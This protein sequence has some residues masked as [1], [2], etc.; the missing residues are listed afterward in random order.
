MRLVE[1]CHVTKYYPAK[2]GEYPSDISKFLKPCVLQ[3]N[4][5]K[6]KKHNSLYLP[7]KYAPIFVLGHNLFLK[8]HSFPQ[9]TLLENCP[10]TYPSIFV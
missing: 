4:F 9:A 1:K 2:T 5:L 7:Q 6:D 3:K 8:A 10:Q